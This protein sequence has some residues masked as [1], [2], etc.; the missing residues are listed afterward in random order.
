MQEYL[1][2]IQDFETIA[3]TLV[4]AICTV[5]ALGRFLR[6]EV[7]QWWPAEISKPKPKQK[8]KHSR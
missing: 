1:K 3:G 5:S 2:S 7:R 8:R 6:D 4:F